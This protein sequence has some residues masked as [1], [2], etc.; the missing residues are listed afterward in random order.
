MHAIHKALKTAATFSA[1]LPQGKP[2]LPV[3]R[4]AAGMSPVTLA[5]DVMVG[6][7]ALEKKTA[8]RN[9]ETTKLLRRTFSRDESLLGRH[10][11][12]CACLS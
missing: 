10:A 12:V 2:P 8:Q 11:H 7:D 3:T 1:P 9:N 6:Y 4:A 5:P